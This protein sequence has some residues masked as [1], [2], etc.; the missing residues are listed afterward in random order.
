MKG[1]LS[2]RYFARDCIV[3]R[4]WGSHIRRINE[5]YQLPARF[6]FM[7][8]L[9]SSLN[10]TKKKREKR[11]NIHFSR[12]FNTHV[13][14]YIFLLYYLFYLF[15]YKIFQYFIFI[16]TFSVECRESQIKKIWISYQF[17]ISTLI[18]DLIHLF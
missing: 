16:D 2:R 15:S 13:Y 11:K 12:I 7:N 9:Y 5:D 10:A 14:V 17:S 18:L 4:A 3:I 8:S 6:F 1:V